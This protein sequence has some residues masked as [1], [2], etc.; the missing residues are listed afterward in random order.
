MHHYIDLSWLDIRLERLKLYFEELTSNLLHLE[1]QYQFLGPKFHDVER[2]LGRSRPRIDDFKPN[3]RGWEPRV[4]TIRCYFQ[5]LLVFG[6]I[7]LFI[8]SWSIF[9]L[10]GRSSSESNRP[11]S[12][13]SVF[14][15]TL[16]VCFAI[17][18]LYWEKLADT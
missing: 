15:T 7:V 4:R 2:H 12:D 3:F 13:N 16:G 17:V 10:R 18:S 9:L 1:P 11:E 8:I 5:K 14:N 6:L